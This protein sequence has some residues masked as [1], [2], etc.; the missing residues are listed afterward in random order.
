MRALG[1][2]CEILFC[3]LTLFESRGLELFSLIWSTT[4]D[5]LAGFMR[6]LGRYR[7]G[8]LA[9]SVVSVSFDSCYIFAFPLLFPIGG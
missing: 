9:L 3:I 2:G 4:M 5:D 1:R 7:E 6:F 8:C